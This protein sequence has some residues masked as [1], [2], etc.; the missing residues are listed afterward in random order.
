MT[1]RVLVFVT[2]VSDVTKRVSYTNPPVLVTLTTAP[3]TVEVCQ[4]VAVVI[5]VAI[6]KS[7]LLINARRAGC[8]YVEVTWTC[9][10]CKSY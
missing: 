3:L 2:T 6:V 8:V 9:V 10:V 1:T 4:A 7:Y 5:D